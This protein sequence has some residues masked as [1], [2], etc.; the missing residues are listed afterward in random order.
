[1]QAS[2]HPLSIERL[3]HFARIQRRGGF[4][5]DSRFLLDRLLPAFPDGGHQPGGDWASE[6]R[7]GIIAG[8]S[9]FTGAKAETST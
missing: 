1:V 8:C 7:K 2:L 6:P 5:L 4:E 9:G 3:F